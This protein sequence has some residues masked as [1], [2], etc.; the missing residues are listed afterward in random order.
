M[1]KL[2]QGLILISY[3]T[4]IVLYKQIFQSDKCDCLILQMEQAKADM[5]KRAHMQHDHAV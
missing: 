5:A 3:L 4:H 1:S 2:S